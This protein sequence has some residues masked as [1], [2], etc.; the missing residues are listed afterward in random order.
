VAKLSKNFDSAEFACHC[1]C[2][3]TITDPNARII[4]ALQRLRNVLGKPITVI[5]GARCSAHNRA[6]GGA[7]YSQHKLL[8]AA[9]ILAP[10]L[11]Q[12]V[13]LTFILSLPEFK[14]IGIEW[15]GSERQRYIHVD[16]RNYVA[17][18]S[19]GGKTYTQAR[20]AINGR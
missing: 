12:N 6:V 5:S 10:G 14:G 2:G 9:D 3:L 7:K 18:W 17:R 11:P 8:N 1:G 15:R 19:Y 16:C 4:L 13:L 20:E